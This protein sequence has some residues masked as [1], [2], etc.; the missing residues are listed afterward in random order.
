MVYST[1][2]ALFD[3][4]E[5]VRSA[6][7]QNMFACG[8]FIDQ[9]KAFDTVNHHIFLHKLDHYGIRGLQISGFKAFFQGDL[10]TQA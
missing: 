9:L 5:K 10:N 7:D 8:I 3:S 6:L 1:N 4:T 2:H